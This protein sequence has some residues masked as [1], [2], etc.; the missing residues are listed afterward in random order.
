MI[1]LTV[2][3]ETESPVDILKLGLNISGGHPLEHPIDKYLFL[4]VLT[5]AGLVLI[6]STNAASSA[7]SSGPAA[8]G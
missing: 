1:R 5:D 3:P 4:D 2:L 6:Y 7:P 8:H